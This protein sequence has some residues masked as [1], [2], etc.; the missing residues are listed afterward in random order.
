MAL[1]I[2]L[3]LYRHFLFHLKRVL[4]NADF[5]ESQ[6]KFTVTRRSLFQGHLKQNRKKFNR[7]NKTKQNKEKSN[8][9]KL[10]D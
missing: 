3:C 6:H 2:T 1:A 8:Y 9:F 5:H 10:A 7:K 4:I